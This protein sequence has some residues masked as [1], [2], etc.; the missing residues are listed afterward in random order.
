MTILSLAEAARPRPGDP[1]AALGAS[2]AYAFDE[3]CSILVGWR[4]R[5]AVLR[6]LS[7]DTAVVGGVA[8][9]RPG[10]TVR[11]VLYRDEVTVRDCRV[12]RTTLLGV[13]L[14]RS[15]DAGLQ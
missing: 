7:T 11:L 4:R 9:L 10:D 1:G 5:D 8:G 3:A 15:G 12:T 2:A 13:E 6:M 14:T